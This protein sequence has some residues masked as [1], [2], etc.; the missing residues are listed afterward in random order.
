MLQFDLLRELAQ[1]AR[2]RPA[3]KRIG[4]SPFLLS[5][6]PCWVAL[7][8]F[9]SNLMGLGLNELVRKNSKTRK[10]ESKYSQGKV[11][12]DARPSSDLGWVWNTKEARSQKKLKIWKTHGAIRKILEY[13]TAWTFYKL[14]K[15]E[16]VPEIFS[17]LSTKV[18]YWRLSKQNHLKM[19]ISRDWIGEKIKSCWFNR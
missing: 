12:R 13:N 18:A 3:S 1:Q 14:C 15:E 19:I 16:A 8:A 4:I 9:C 10:Y 6:T 2:A 7:L 5:E 17:A 11:W